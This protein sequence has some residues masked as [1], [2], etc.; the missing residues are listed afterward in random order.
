MFC[1]DLQSKQLC[2]SS[3]LMFSGQYIAK[4]I[5]EKRGDYACSLLFIMPFS[6]IRFNPSVK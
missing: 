1:S 5:C 3:L 6:P 2:L 4:A